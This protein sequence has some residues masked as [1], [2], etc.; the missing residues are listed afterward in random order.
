MNINYFLRKQNLLISKISIEFIRTDYIEHL[1]E[2]EKLI[3]IIGPRGVGKTTLLLQFLKQ[4]SQKYLYFSADDVVFQDLKLYDLVDEAYSL[5]RKLIVIDEIHKYKNWAGEI[6]N[7]YDSFPDI[8]IR[9]SGSSMIN[10]LFEKYDLSRRL[11]L[12]KVPHL[13]FREF[14]SMQ[15]FETF[16]KLE[17]EDILENAEQLSS[18]LVFKYDDLYALFKEYLEYGAY[19]FFIEGKK[20][21]SKKLF[22]ALDKVINED[23]PSLNK[24]DYAHVIIFKK[25]I[26]R[27]VEAEKPFQVNVAKLSREFGISEPTLY[28]YFEILEKSRIFT[29]IKKYSKKTSKKPEKL[30]FSNSN[31][32]YSYAN[33]FDKEV[34]IGTVRETFFVNC[35]E[36]IFYSDVGDFRVGEYLFEVGGK[37]K[38]FKQIKDMENSY[39]VADLDYTVNDKKI[40]LWLFGFLS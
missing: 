31:I 35:F 1:R 10:I 6:K 16:E 24:I 40:P 13:S 5:G 2:N 27:L 19:P 34:E 29:P 4:S 3:G 15:K 18:D 30:L 9:I 26:F 32:L 38:S 17:L 25:L 28:T 23:I 22:N 7:I 33:E 20:N 14:F 36:K 39:V 11:V 37:N 12:Y 21:F 8:Q